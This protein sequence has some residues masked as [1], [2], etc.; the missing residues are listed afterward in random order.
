MSR[1][2]TWGDEYLIST[3]G[4]SY[5]ATSLGNFGLDHKPGLNSSEFQLYVAMGMPQCLH[6][7]NGSESTTTWRL[8]KD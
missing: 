4:P 7:E 6:L 1:A 3:S 5:C 2:G 8:Y